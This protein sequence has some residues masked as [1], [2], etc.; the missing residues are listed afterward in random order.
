MHKKMFKRALIIAVVVGS[1]LNVI[2]Q[3]DAVLGQNS[4]NWY[5]AILTYCVPFFVSLVSGW[6]ANRDAK[7]AK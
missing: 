2:N 3:Y 5:K 1:V 6:L 4:V 7:P